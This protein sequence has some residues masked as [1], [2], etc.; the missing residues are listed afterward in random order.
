MRLSMQIIAGWRSELSDLIRNERSWGTS[1]LEKRQRMSEPTSRSIDRRFGKIEANPLLKLCKSSPF[2]DTSIRTIF[3]RVSWSWEESRKV[4]SQKSY[5]TRYHPNLR[6]DSIPP[7]HSLP[8]HIRNGSQKLE[9]DT[10]LSDPASSSPL[11]SFPHLL[12]SPCLVRLLLQ[13]L[14]EW[15]KFS[16]SSTKHLEVDDM[17][18]LQCS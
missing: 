17:L 15:S 2:S 14:D 5:L 6:K 1:M 7:V 8:F 16:D 4:L 10:A 12:V 13:N 11:S 9:R 3:R 18:H